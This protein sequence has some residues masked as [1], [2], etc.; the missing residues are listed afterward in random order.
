MKELELRDAGARLPALVDEVVQGELVAI[1]Q[2]GE[3][4]AV[5]LSYEEWLRLSNVPSFGRLLMA[6]PL[7]A[8]DISG[9]DRYETARHVVLEASH[10]GRH[11]T[12][13]VGPSQLFLSS[14]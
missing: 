4:L 5:I 8:D 11:T 6:A 7:T 9:F 13:S 14:Q 2:S 12:P 10:G 3:K 1:T